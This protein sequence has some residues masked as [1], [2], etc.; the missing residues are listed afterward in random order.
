M[1]AHFEQNIAD[2]VQCQTCEVL[3]A[4][5]TNVQ[6]DGVDQVPGY[7][8]MCKSVTSPS[9]RA[10]ATNDRSAYLNI[11]NRV[12]LITI[13]TIQERQQVE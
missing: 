12:L 3:I 1:P 2:E 4:R 6:L 10:L 5:C 9:S 13:T 8:L 11:E 7:S